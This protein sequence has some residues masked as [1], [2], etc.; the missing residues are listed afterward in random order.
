M[1]IKYTLTRD[2]LYS[3]YRY[4]HDKAGGGKKTRSD[5]ARAWFISCLA[6]TM[7]LWPL[8]QN[9]AIVLAAAVIAIAAPFYAQKR[10]DEAVRKTYRRLVSGIDIIFG[11][12][13]LTIDEN[14]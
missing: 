7:L 12:H 1:T 3:W 8:T 14:G 2:D 6:G 13:Q 10:Y 11:E 9:V 4:W 5:Y